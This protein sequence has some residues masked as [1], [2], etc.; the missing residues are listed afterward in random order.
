MLL[1][2]AVEYLGTPLKSTRM[3]IY[4]SVQPTLAPF[5]GRVKL[6][7]LIAY[8]FPVICLHFW[9]KRENCSHN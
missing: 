3:Q 4:L 9:S 5:V 1:N 2:A 8:V 6:A 7:A